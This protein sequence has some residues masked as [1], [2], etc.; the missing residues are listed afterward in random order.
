MK[1]STNSP[2][3]IVAIFNKSV[4]LIIFTICCCASIVVAQEQ[5][6]QD[7]AT[8]TKYHVTILS[9]LGGN[10]SIGN[11][12]NNRGW[13]SGFSNLSGNQNRHAMLWRHGFAL[14]LGTL[15]GPNSNITWPVKNNN[16]TLI[17]ISQTSTP[18][19]LGE[20]WSC[21]AF[22]APATS[23]GYT[24]L[25]FV[26]ENGQMKSLPTLGGNNGFAAGA[27]KHGQIVGWAENNIQDSSCVSPQVL[28]F[29]AVIW[30]FK[31]DSIHELSPIY[32]IDSTSA[33]TAINNKGQVVGISGKCDVAV[34]RFSARKAVRWVVGIPF[35]LEDLGLNAWNTPNA[36]NDDGIIVGFA[37]VPNTNPDDFIT[38]AVLWNKWG[39][40]RN[41]GTLYDADTTSQ[42]IGINKYGQVVGLSGTATTRRAFIWE[43]GVMEDLN[44]LIPKN[45]NGILEIAGDINDYGEITGRAFLNDTKERVTFVAIPVK[46]R[47]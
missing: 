2:A 11:S 38:R 18:D 17:G 7:E 28:Q 32:P 5:Q 40:I 43:N 41:L 39:S 35:P 12:I 16:G 13:V 36:I 21:S 8:T 44:N 20:S 34:G 27:N 31:K 3:R 10:R 15:G 4:L 14:D 46:T 24:C 37:G 9:S 42:A 6:Q 23:T 47:K 25:G 19:P 45:F 33:A 22:F 1:Q 26:W 30:N 29:K